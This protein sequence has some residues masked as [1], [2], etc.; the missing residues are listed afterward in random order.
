[1]KYPQFSVA[2]SVYKNDNAVFFERA[3]ES[4]TINQTIVPS[5]IVI[6]EDG[7]VTHEIEAVI[8]KFSTNYLIKVI[9]IPTNQGLGIALRTAVDNCTHELIARMDADDVSVPNRFEQQ[10]SILN[11]NPTID[12]IGGDISEFIENENNIVGYRNVPIE[13]EKIKK[14][15]KKRCPFNHV[16]V[17]F[18]KESILKAGGYLDWHYN[19]DYYLW[20]RMLLSDSIFANS[21]TVLVNVRTGYNQY[22]RRGGKAYFASEIGL[23]KLMLQKRIINVFTFLSNWIK[24]FIVQILMPNKI[25][26]AIIKTFARKKRK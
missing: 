4:I 17:L 14:Y 1:M 20:I 24:R 22:S 11:T 23:Q 16:T 2:M 7:P 19:E 10:L 8:K 18:K 13:D 6:V 12:I 26:G 3:L 25:R 5:E 9:R 21:G 15:L